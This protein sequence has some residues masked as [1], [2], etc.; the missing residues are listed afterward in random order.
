MSTECRF[1]ALQY[2]NIKLESI[3]RRATKMGKGLEGKVYEEWLRPFALCS[4]EQR[5]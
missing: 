4:P 3:Q 5:S 2:K 1:G